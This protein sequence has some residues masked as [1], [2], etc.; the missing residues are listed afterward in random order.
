[1]RIRISSVAAGLF[2]LA[3][4]LMAL[5]VNEGRWRREHRRGEELRLELAADALSADAARL[6]H[7]ESHQADTTVRFWAAVTGLRVT[8]IDAGG[9]VHAESWTVPALLD[10]VVDHL[11]REEVQAAA[12]GEKV[13]ARRRSETTG[14]RTTYHARALGGLPPLGYLRVAHEGEGPGVPWLGVLVALLTAAVVTGATETALRRRERAVLRHLA[15]WSDLPANADLEAVSADLSQAFSE[16]GRE[17]ERRLEIK[18]AALGQL[19]EGIVIVDRGGSVSFFNA[20]AGTL[21]GGQLAVGR[22]L[23][24]AVRHPDLLAAVQ[25]VSGEGGIQ[26]TECLGSGDVELAVRVCALD[27]PM[28]AIAIVL[29]DTR[30]ERQLERARRALVADLAHELRT[31][32][33][34][35]GG[36]TEELREE[37]DGDELVLSLERQLRRLRTFAEELEEL[38]ALETGQVRLEPEDVDAAVVVRQVLEELAGAAAQKDVMLSQS[39]DPCPVRTDSVR[40]SQVLSNLVDNGIRYNRPGG[41][42]TVSLASRADAVQIVVE[43]TGIGIPAAEVPLVFQRFYRVRRGAQPN[44]GSGLG[45]AIVKHLVHALK[46]TVQMTS[47]EG[48]GTRVTVQLPRLLA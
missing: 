27:R 35:L 39:G 17:Y 41:A 23:V 46:G 6:L 1:M 44:G 25:R 22:P 13:Y 33:T 36:L 45:L 48:R 37:R 7:M 30:G 9:R 4:V 2:A 47:E 42:V 38:A 21:L 32:L 18:R 10:R 29:R 11:G 31:P 24:E 28:M 43:D 15:P 12:R 16:R 3:L 19:G 26:N 20:A 34:V 14:R 5:G 40:L 8:L